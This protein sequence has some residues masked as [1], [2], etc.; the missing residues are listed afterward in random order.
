MAKKIIAANWK[1]NLMREEAISLFN[2]VKK[3]LSAHKETEIV[4]FPPS[5]YISDLI[6]NHP[7]I[8]VGAQN[9]YFEEKGAFTGEISPFQLKNIGCNY[10][11]IGHSERRELFDESNEL[12]SKKMRSALD[13]NLKII[14]CCGETLQEREEV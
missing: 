13:A 12:L 6:S 4:V 9:F 3:G 7:L 1:M 5:I 11:L 2:G 14:Y 10:V 8:E